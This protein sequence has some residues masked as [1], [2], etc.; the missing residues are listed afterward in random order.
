MPGWRALALAA[1]LS[2]GGST[3]LACGRPDCDDDG[4]SVEQGDCDDDDATV[5][6]RAK[7]EFELDVAYCLDEIDNNCD[8]L[9]NEGCPGDV[10]MGRIGGGGACAEGGAVGAAG[11]FVLPFAWRRRRV[12]R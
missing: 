2:A 5:F 1:A 4:F 12:R 8:G 11:L 7:A 9:I 6:P 3:A 10:A